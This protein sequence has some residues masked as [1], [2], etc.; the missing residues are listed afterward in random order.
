MLGPQKGRIGCG[1]GREEGREDTSFPQSVCR[2]LGPSCP[3]GSHVERK[4]LFWYPQLGCLVLSKYREVL[5]Q[6][7]EIQSGRTPS[8]HLSIEMLHWDKQEAMAW[9]MLARRPRYEGVKHESGCR[10]WWEKLPTLIFTLSPALGSLGGARPSSKL[11]SLV[12]LS[13]SFLLFFLVLFL[14]WTVLL[15]WGSYRCGPP[16]NFHTLHPSSVLLNVCVVV[17]LHVLEADSLVFQCQLCPLP[18]VLPW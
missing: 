16:C 15:F 7:E 17:K 5:K 9:G 8:S 12:W 10:V 3:P 11:V 2:D 6:K 1:D 4:E 13:Y 14:S 18:A